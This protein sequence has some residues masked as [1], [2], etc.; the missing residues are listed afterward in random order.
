MV[1]GND[2]HA[3]PDRPRHDDDSDLWRLARRLLR[4]QGYTALW[5]RYGEDMAS[6]EIARIM[7]RPRIW[8]SVTLH[9]AC[10]L[11]REHVHINGNPAGA[12]KKVPAEV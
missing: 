7:R 4:P 1:I 6:G 10:A 12:A 3:A 8:V 11:L 9:R 2:H 5:L